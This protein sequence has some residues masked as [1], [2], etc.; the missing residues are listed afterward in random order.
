MA[1]RQLPLNEANALRSGTQMQ[2]PTF[3]NYYS[4]GQAGAAP[5]MDA[6]MAQQSQANAI[7]KANND[8]ANATMAAI[9][10]IA[11]A[12]SDSR[13]KTNLKWLG[14]HPAGIPR[15]SWDWANGYGSSWG[16]LAQDL[17]K[18]RP[19]AVG[20]VD[21]FLAVDYAKIGGR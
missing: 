4:S 14:A 20:E 15:Y 13:L 19:D 7:N 12:F 1:L 6:A 3:Q 2:T 10:S 16:V 11:M 21:G 8:S 5:V 9:A 18:V 17:Q